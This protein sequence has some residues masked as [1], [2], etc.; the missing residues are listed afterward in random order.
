MQSV[1]TPNGMIAKGGDELCDAFETSQN[2]ENMK[3]KEKMRF[4]LFGN[5]IFIKQLPFIRWPLWLTS[6]STRKHFSAISR[7]FSL[8]YFNASLQHLT[9]LCMW[10][11]IS[12]HNLN[13]KI[14]SAILH[15]WFVFLTFHEFH[16][17][18]QCPS[19]VTF[20]DQPLSK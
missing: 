9:L 5:K 11:E 14:W 15:T 4:R 10:L 13:S 2:F 18:P 3:K 7:N 17:R 20:Y 19:H 12:L 6:L 16:T 8:R 1:S